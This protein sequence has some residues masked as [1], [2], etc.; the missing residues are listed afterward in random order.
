MES[1]Q[2]LNNWRPDTLLL[3]DE[4]ASKALRREVNTYELIIS[5]MKED[6]FFK[7]CKELM[8]NPKKYQGLIEVLIKNYEEDSDK[9][10]GG[11]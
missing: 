3:R 8:E 9:D 11:D 6:S 1:P 5:N 4:I 2:P 7:A 10:K